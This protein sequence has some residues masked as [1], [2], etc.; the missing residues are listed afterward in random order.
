MKNI[1]AVVNC[2]KD[3]HGRGYCTK[4]YQQFKSS[5]IVTS[6]TR[7]K[8]DPNEFVVVGSDC[9][10]KL[11]DDRGL[12]LASA[13]IDAD[14]IALVIQ[15]KWRLIGEK[16]YA[17]SWKCRAYLHNIISGGVLVDH[18]DGDPLNN[19]RAN[20][21]LATAS[22]NGMNRG[23]QSNNTSGYKGV[24]FDK[25]KGKWAARICANKKTHH[26]GYFDDPLS[27]ALAYNKEA[28][29][30]HGNFANINA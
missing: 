21:R 30:I 25:Q 10:I 18:I 28:K 15:F 12:E 9:F 14:D 24:V 16:R 8:R 3:V 27:A 6:S 29:Q 22:E 11:F 20:L 7:T 1:C 17:H 2:N 13:V 23:K 4:H 26:I 19:R 5:G